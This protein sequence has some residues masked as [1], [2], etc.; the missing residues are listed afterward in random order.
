[1][2]EWFEW[3]AEQNKS[4]TRLIIFKDK[5]YTLWY[6]PLLKSYNENKVRVD[7]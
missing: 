4:N 3:Q 7:S 1:M 5:D 6:D 2:S